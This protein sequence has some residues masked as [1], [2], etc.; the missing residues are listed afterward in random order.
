[1]TLF[2]WKT[3][4]KITL[5]DARMSPLWTAFDTF[6]IIHKAVY[7]ASTAFTCVCSVDS[8]VLVLLSFIQCKLGVKDPPA[9]YFPHRVAL[10]FIQQLKN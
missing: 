2:M 7:P 10:Q 9:L 5:M 8:I 4:L 6:I 1:M 3:F